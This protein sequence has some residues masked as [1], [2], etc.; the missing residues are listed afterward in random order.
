MKKGVSIILTAWNTQ[1]YIK[2]C[3]D[4]V[5]KQDFF[6]GNNYE[7]LLGI[8]ACDKTFKRVKEIMGDYKNLKVF[9]FKDNVGTYVVSNTL[10][11]MAQYEYLYRFD[12]DD[13]MLP[14]AVSTLI[15]YAEKHN[16]DL[17]LSKCQNMYSTTGKVDKKGILAHGQIFIKTDTF[18]D[19]GGFRPF[20]C[21]ADSE[22]FQRIKNFIAFD[23]MN[24]SC[25]YRRLHSTNLTGIAATGMK[26]EYRKYI[27]AFLLYERDKLIKTKKDA[28]IKCVTAPCYEVK[29]GEIS[30]TPAENSFKPMEIA[31]QYEIFMKLPE[32]ERKK[33]IPKRFSSDNTSGLALSVT[34]NGYIRKRAQS[35]WTGYM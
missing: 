3:L 20:K 31:D 4:S 6:K 14:N 35:S 13:I 15:S 12:T 10:A 18:L 25:A 1:E 19:F 33:Y 24:K 34:S 17:V 22:L 32:S 21:G 29:D 5:S 2:E 16:D 26:S 23:T 11:S 27:H 28:R 7:I 30:E 9:Y 8:D